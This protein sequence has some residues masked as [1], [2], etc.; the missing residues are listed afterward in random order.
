MSDEVELHVVEVAVVI[1][2]DSS[3]AVAF[4]SALLAH[5]EAFARERGFEVVRPGEGGRQVHRIRAPEDDLRRGRE[6][7]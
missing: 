6:R 1:V 7:S 5:A 4:S 3:E 2:A